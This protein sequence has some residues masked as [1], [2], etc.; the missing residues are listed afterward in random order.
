VTALRIANC[1]G[2]FGDRLSAA[3]EM[4]DGGPIDVLTGDWLAELTMLI[5][6]RQRARGSGSGYAGTF[7]TQ[8]EQVLGTCLERGIKVVSNAGGLDPTGC[9]DALSAI[10]A[11]LGLHPRIGV[12][13]G[14]D[15]LPR[16]AQ[17]R[18]QGETFVNLETGETMHF[19]PVTANAYAGGFGIAAA[20]RHDADVV[21]TGRVTDAALVV[22]PGVWRFG[23]TCDDLDALAG[24]VVAGHILECGAQATGGNYS[25]FREVPGIDKPGFP[26][27]V[28]E[29]DGSAV[30]T[31]HPGTGGQVSVGTLTAQLLYE[32][33]SP[34]YVNPDVVA[35][36]DTILLQHTE[37]DQVRVSGVQGQPPPPRMKV[38]MTYIAGYRNSMSFM[39]TGLDV[40]AKA[41]V[42]LRGL[43]AAI[44]GG[45]SAFDEVATELLRG[46]PWSELRVTVK[47]RDQ[48]RV[49]RRFSSACVELAL[50]NYPGL[51]TRTPPG[52][53]VPYGVY[54]PTSVDASLVT[55]RVC[56][57]GV[58]VAEVASDYRGGTSHRGAASGVSEALARSAPLRDLEGVVSATFVKERAQRG[59]RVG[60]TTKMPLGRVAGARSGDKGGN[61]NV[62]FWVKSDAAYPWLLQAVTSDFIREV[63]PDAAALEI[64]RYELPNLRAINFVIKKLLG[65]GVA[66]ST[67]TDPQAK[68]L[69]EYFRAQLVDVPA[70]ILAAQ[71]G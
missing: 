62:G 15:L 61:A 37:P 25:F 57:D 34:A 46:D 39:L 53:A 71:E 2:F 9:A 56:V 41:E 36:F 23:W 64:E 10:A 44:P 45:P 12:V 30:I 50:A 13:E 65:R 6:A 17:L 35:R 22:G 11:R 18:A 66:D 43:W 14:D 59:G 24:A 33:D 3:R 48:K 5:L 49:G 29:A 58:L 38:A 7:L 20:L 40:E 32:I 26:I 69:G 63:L 60:P 67:R 70:S 28:L 21:I 51:F 47:D 27:A 4:V 1:S 54:W 68:G 19:E 31:K 52:D 8:M 42:A 55:Q 16:L